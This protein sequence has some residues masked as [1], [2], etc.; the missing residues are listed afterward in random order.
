MKECDKK[1]NTGSNTNT[2]LTNPYKPEM[3]AYIIF[4]HVIHVRSAAEAITAKT[5]DYLAI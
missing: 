3:S 5:L 2:Y 4:S 1:G